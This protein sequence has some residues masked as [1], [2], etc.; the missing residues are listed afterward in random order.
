M[1]LH[2]V[3]PKNIEASFTPDQKT[4]WE[5]Y[6]KLFGAVPGNQL[7]YSAAEVLVRIPNILVC[8]VTLYLLSCMFV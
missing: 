1:A 2:L 3:R 4:A 6:T 7:E 5:P 8:I